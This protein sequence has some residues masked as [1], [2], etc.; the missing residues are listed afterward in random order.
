MKA[1]KSAAVSVSLKVLFAAEARKAAILRRGP[2]EHYHLISWDLETDRFQHGQWLRG[3]VRLSDLSPDGK[4]LIYWAAQY[5]RPRARA[6]AV[7]Y[8]EPTPDLVRT[9]GRRSIPRYVREQALPVSPAPPVDSFSTWTAVSKPPYFTALAIWPSFGTW[10]G[11][12]Y[13]DRDGSIHL[14]EFSSQPITNAGP[15]DVP[16]HLTQSTLMRTGHLAEMRSA[17]FGALE[18]DA[19]HADVALE[20]YMAGADRIH[21]VDL[22]ARTGVSFA[23]DG[24]VYRS[25]EQPTSAPAAIVANACAI[26]DFNGLT[27]E[28][29]PPAPYALQW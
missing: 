20:L 3:V 5:H 7:S 19:R 28:Q 14:A 6:T 2:R 15:P 29:V 1:I 24:R 26:A 25:S 9:R 21:W 10:T 17:R 18:V 16:I 4:R 23:Y 13:F 11:G 8:Y 27:F 12:G 22:S